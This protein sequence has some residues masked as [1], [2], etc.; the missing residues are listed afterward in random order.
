MADD[1]QIETNGSEANNQAATNNEQVIVGSG[2]EPSYEPANATDTFALW[3]EKAVH[4]DEP[5]PDAP[6]AAET[7]DKEGGSEGERRQTS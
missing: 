4:A 5:A 6:S 3:Q 1:P 2:S 7:A